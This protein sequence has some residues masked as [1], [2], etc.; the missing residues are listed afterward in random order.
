MAP[1]NLNAS[2]WRGVYVGGKGGRVIIR[3]RNLLLLNS[4]PVSQ[5][6]FMFNFVPTECR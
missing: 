1:L 5:T 3:M 6:S 2:L 4:I